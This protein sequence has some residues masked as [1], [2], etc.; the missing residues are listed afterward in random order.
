M[1]NGIQVPEWALVACDLRDE[2]KLN[3][4]QFND[5]VWYLSECGIAGFMNTNDQAR[6]CAQRWIAGKR[7]VTPPGTK[8]RK[9]EAKER[10]KVMLNLPKALVDAISNVVA[11]DVFKHV[12]GGNEKAANSLMGMVMRQ[13]KADPQLIK[14]LL[15]AEI[16][17]AK[18]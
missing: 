10:K 14:Q 13:H 9:R 4:S 11:S 15:A 8:R 18:S 2:H 3:Q 1:T 12:V 7:K 16:E 17:K 5:M 6:L